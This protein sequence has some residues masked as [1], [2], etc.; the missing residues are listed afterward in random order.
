VE[1]VK[2][3][4]MD[5]E[6]HEFEVMSGASEFMRTYPP[7]YI[8]F[9][10]NERGSNFSAT[11]LV[12]LLKA[13]GFSRMYEVPHNLLSSRIRRLDGA[14]EPGPNSVNFLGVHDSVTERLF[15]E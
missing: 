8:I 10:H 14:K 2:L 3:F 13:L 12:I 4:K 11:P 5:V 7:N 9:E 15:D 1:K 6:G